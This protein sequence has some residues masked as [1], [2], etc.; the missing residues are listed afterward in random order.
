MDSLEIIS[1]I[2]A[3]DDDWNDFRTLKGAWP[4]E[5]AL[6]KKFRHDPLEKILQ[7]RDQLTLIFSS[8]AANV[9]RSILFCTEF[10]RL[11]N[12]FY[13]YTFNFSFYYFF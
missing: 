9:T 10:F 11:M 3:S 12:M 4:P 13:L 8:N 7:L 2:L 5:R 1:Q 6:W